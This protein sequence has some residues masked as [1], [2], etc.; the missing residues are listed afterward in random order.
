MMRSIAKLLFPPRCKACKLL[1][2]FRGI[3]REEPRVLCRE[4]EST[5]ENA[6]LDMCGY[7]G[8]AV[9]RCVCM[10]N[11][12]KRAKCELLRKAVYYLPQKQDAV[13]DRLIFL[14]KDRADRRLAEFFAQQLIVEVREISSEHLLTPLNTVLVYIPRS[15]RSVRVTG[16]D[17]SERLAKALSAQ[18]GFQISPAIVRRPLKNKPQK[19]LGLKDRIRNAIDS[20]VLA[21]GISLKGKNVLLLDDIVTTGASMAVASRLLRRAGA[22]RVFA[23]TI[24]YDEANKLPIEAQPKFRI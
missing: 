17:Q 2:P 1:L 7:C 3:D 18:T 22:E 21:K 12:L 4:C 6:K 20:Y 5:W 10:P 24:A 19:S 11:E 9:S 13:Q 16:T 8:E 23:L 15:R 14:A